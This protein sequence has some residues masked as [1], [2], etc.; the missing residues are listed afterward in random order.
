MAA[1]PSQVRQNY[2]PVCEAAVTAQIQLQLYASYVYL[3]MAFYCDR[4]DVA[5]GNFARFF[6]RQSHE[7]KARAEKLLFMQN[8][9]GGRICLGD[10]AKPDRDDWLSGLQVM[11]CAFHLELTITKSILELHQLATDKGDPHLRH[12]LQ[13][14][15]LRQQVETLGELTGYL[16]DLRKVGAPEDGLTEYLCDRLTLGD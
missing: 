14:H 8:Q 4:D 10:V 7:W 1:A 16:T 6:L 5:L 2:H 12:F 15:Y 11:E 13:R 9:R 3:S